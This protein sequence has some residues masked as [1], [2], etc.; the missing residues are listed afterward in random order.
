MPRVIGIRCGRKSTATIPG[1]APGSR[2]A[3]AAI[4]AS[5]CSISATCRWPADAVRLDAL[6]DLAEMEL[7][8]GLASRPGDAALGVDDE[9]A[10]QSGPRQR[11]ECQERGGGVAAGCTDD[12]DVGIDEGRQLGSM[13]LGQPVDRLVEEVRSWVLEPVPAWIVGRIPQPEVGTLVDDRPCPPAT[14]SG[15]SA[16]AVPC[17]RAMNTASTGGRSAWT[18]SPVPTR[19]GWIPSIGFVIATAARRGR[20]SATLGWRAR[21]RT[22]SAPT[23]PVAPMIPTRTRRGPPAPSTPRSERGSR[24]AV[25]AEWMAVTRA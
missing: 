19:W 21:R 12:R 2:P 4:A 10:D 16:A 3:P 17:G 7:G 6:V 22:S 13:Q 23:Y 20:P 5:S 24:V 15:T 18:V 14:R 25:G 1:L 11:G 8:F 9:V